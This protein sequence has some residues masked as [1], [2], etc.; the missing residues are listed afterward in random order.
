M[1][2][3]RSLDRMRINIGIDLG[4]RLDSPMYF[5]EETGPLRIP[6][7]DVEKLAWRSTV[8]NRSGNIAVGA[9]DSNG[10]APN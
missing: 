1:N 4:T 10:G 9:R 7:F 6:L 5:S 2:P 3:L 8:V